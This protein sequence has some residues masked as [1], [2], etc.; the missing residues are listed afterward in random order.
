MFNGDR[1]SVWEV[2][3][4]VCMTLGHSLNL[5]RQRSGDCQASPA[6]L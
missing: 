1:V 6:E 2:S 5:S 3:R 4:G